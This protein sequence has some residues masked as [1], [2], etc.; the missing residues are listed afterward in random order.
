VPLGFSPL[1][2]GE[3]VQEVS[4]ALL[5]LDSVGAKMLKLEEV[6]CDQL[7]A[8]GHVLAEKVVEHVLMCFRSQDP[9]VSLDLVMLRP[10]AGIEEAA[11]NDIQ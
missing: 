2:S 7:E 11:S 4:T 8:E 10:I 5:L 6:I 1:R 9:V 3:P